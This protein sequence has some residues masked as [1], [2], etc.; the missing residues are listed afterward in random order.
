MRGERARRIDK[1]AQTDSKAV[2]WARLVNDHNKS[3]GDQT[4]V[5]K[6]KEFDVG[7]R[8][9]GKEKEK[10]RERREKETEREVEGVKREERQEKKVMG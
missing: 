4:I 7:G 1:F 10:E 2:I 8:E 3:A 5:D 6:Q 9:R